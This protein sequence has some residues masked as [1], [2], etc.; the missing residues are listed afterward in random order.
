MRIVRL[1][2][3]NVTLNWNASSF[4]YFI[5]RVQQ[6]FTYTTNTITTTKTTPVNILT[7]LEKSESSY[8]YC[9]GGGVGWKFTR[10]REIMLQSFFFTPHGIPYTLIPLCIPSP[11]LVIQD[12]RTLLIFPYQ[13]LR[14]IS[15]WSFLRV[16]GEI[17]A[18]LND[19]CVCIK[20]VALLNLFSTTGRSQLF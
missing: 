18:S 5:E 7:P 13:V 8:Y 11:I 6:I 17:I 1:C 2:Q 19:I 4:S 14:P 3:W 20:N 10:W 15:N 9:W 16:P 12:T